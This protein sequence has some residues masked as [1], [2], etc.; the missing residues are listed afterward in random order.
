MQSQA[1]LGYHGNNQIKKPQPNKKPLKSNKEEE[2]YED[3][4]S[5]KSH[6]MPDTSPNH[7][8]SL[9]GTFVLSL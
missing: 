9:K 4:W 7:Y 3:L 2:T 1:S 5:L 6:F 8:Q